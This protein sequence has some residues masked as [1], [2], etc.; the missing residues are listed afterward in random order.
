MYK[1]EY[2]CKDF[3]ERELGIQ[4]LKCKPDFLAIDKTKFELD[5]YNEKLKLAFEYQGHHHYMFVPYL[6]KTYEAFERGLA[7]DEH[8]RKRCKEQGVLLVQ[9]R[10]FETD[11]TK[12]REQYLR[13]II[14][15]HKIKEWIEQH[16]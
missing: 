3:L 14:K 7:S 13:D 2:F 1:A 16:K 8:K 5:M 15:E 4:L 6:H 9:I 12:E 11:D 10:Y